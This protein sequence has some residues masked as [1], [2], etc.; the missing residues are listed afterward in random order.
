[1]FT[2]APTHKTDSNTCLVR[3]CL[4]GQIPPPSRPTYFGFCSCF[5][6]DRHIYPP[7]LGQVWVVP[8]T[9]RASARST[10][11]NAGHLS[12]SHFF[13]IIPIVVELALLSILLPTLPL[14][15]SPDF[16]RCSS[17]CVHQIP[18]SA[19]AHAQSLPLPRGHQTGASP[20]AS[21]LSLPAHQPAL[22]RA[23]SRWSGLQV[24][25][26][27]AARAR[28]LV[29]ARC[30]APPCH[31]MHLPRTISLVGHC[32]LTRGMWRSEVFSS[33]RPVR[34]EKEPCI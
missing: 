18:S 26:A 23:I 29:G 25:G 14:L 7:D 19:A 27:M 3:M 31:V 9:C 15:L 34:E 21:G 2:P 12:Y 4:R 20:R 1:M 5:R 24:G 8:D 30:G 17:S 11:V 33:R 32:R 28:G 10:H 6:P 22:P 16:G 13:F